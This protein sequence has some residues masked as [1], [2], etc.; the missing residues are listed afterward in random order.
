MRGEALLAQA[1]RDHQAGRWR[2]AEQAYRQLLQRDPH[3]SEAM[4]WL[5]TMAH[6]LGKQSD[7]VALLAK[8]VQIRPDVSAY[9]CNLGLALHGLGRYDEAVSVLQQAVKSSPDDHAAWLNLGLALKADGQFD[10]A[11]DA[12]SKALELRPSEAAV[13][14]NLAALHQE[15]GDFEAAEKACCEALR[16]QPHRTE[17][18]RSLLM[19]RSVEQEADDRLQA[20]QRLYQQDVVNAAEK[21]HLC[22]ALAKAYEDLQSKEF[23]EQHQD[24]GVSDEA[25]IFI[26][27]MPR[28][29]STLI[30]QIL[31]SHPQVW[32]AGELLDFPRLAL[33]SIAKVTGQSFP[34]NVG[35]LGQQQVVDLA[36]TYLKRL[37][38]HAEGQAFITDKMLANFTL[39]G[40]IQLLLPDARIIHCRRD[41]VDTCLACFRQYFTDRQPFAYDL[42]ELG[43]YYRLYDELMNHW[44]QVLPG[45]VLEVNYEDILSDQAGQT[46]RLLD[47]CK[48]P[49]DDAC[50]DF[51][52]SERVVKTASLAQVRSP[53]YK[54]A[55]GRWRHYEKHLAPLLAEL[56]LAGDQPSH[57]V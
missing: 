43:R 47:Y 32:G 9:Y 37:R 31:S 48:L 40:V 14:S 21:A 5:G 29:G 11:F 45:R 10:A 19:I 25:P 17:C 3:H 35:A 28:S 46:R 55:A 18:Y 57:G 42:A 1:R 33:E 27:G 13:W 50:L 12:Y 44:Q 34:Q 36:Q 23:F 4:F 30:E 24:Y 22:F 16:L 2:Q 38:G 51:H 49:W 20:M 8:A 41:A 15:S 54:G 6:Q 26:V 39:V 56:D 52:R 7:A 53:L